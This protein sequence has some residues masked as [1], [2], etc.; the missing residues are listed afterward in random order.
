MRLFYTL[1][2][3]LSSF[4][5]RAQPRAA[6]SMPSRNGPNEAD[7]FVVQPNLAWKFSARQPFFSSPLIDGER[8]Y[9]GNNDSALY[10]LDM[11]SGKLVWKFLT[12][13]PVRSGVC[14]DHDRLFLIGGDS[15]VYCLDKINGR[16]QWVFRTGGERMYDQYDYYQSTP[17]IRGDTLF[18]GSG[19]GNVYALDHRSG[20]LIWKYGTGNVV[21]GKPALAGGRL[22]IGS[23]DGY[24]YALNTS[25]GSLAWK[26][27][28]VGQRFFPRG[29]MQF[30]PVVVKGLVFIGGRD[31]NL[32]AIDAE[33]G[34][35]HWNRQYARGWAPVVTPTH[36]DSAVLVGT[37]DDK[38]LLELRTEDGK[39][40]W[41]SDVKFNVFGSSVL[42]SN[43]CYTATL[44]GKIFGIDLRTGGISWSF[45]T[46]GYTANRLKYFKEDDTYRD[47]VFS[48]IHS[49]EEYLDALNRL[50]AV[51]SNPAMDGT[52]I[53]FSSTEGIVY[54]LKKA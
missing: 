15:G 5:L 35:C 33:K 29:E 3:V 31:F 9:V 39:E 25:D 41:R 52:H 17:V 6:A 49:Q 32:Y 27:K 10:C 23:F 4:V 24:A 21:H 37:S 12:G 45:G 30:S 50:G 18:F 47:D 43:M 7:D 54:C 34:Y 38:V 22:F 46:E 20:I 11:R 48:V 42:T 13:G 14:I 51:Y 19:D 8:V 53:V 40:I 1:L 16:K 44:M 36:H 26:M 28:S 2:L